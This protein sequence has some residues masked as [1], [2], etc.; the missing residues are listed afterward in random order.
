MLEVIAF[1]ERQEAAEEHEKADDKKVVSHKGKASDHGTT[2]KQ[3][4]DSGGKKDRDC[5]YHGPNTHPSSKVLKSLVDSTKKS[6]TTTATTTTNDGKNGKFKAIRGTA[7]RKKPR[8]PL[9]RSSMPMS[10]R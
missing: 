2:K 10:K 4:T 5:P 8:Q 9:E 7:R 6:R 3:K 1:C